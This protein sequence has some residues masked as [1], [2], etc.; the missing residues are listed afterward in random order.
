MVD[1]HQN[2]KCQDNFTFLRGSKNIQ[3]HEDMQCTYYLKTLNSLAK[4][5]FLQL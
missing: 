5:H 1:P 4:G 2:I 3:K